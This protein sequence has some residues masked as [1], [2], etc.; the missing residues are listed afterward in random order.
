VQLQLPADLFQRLHSGQVA[1]GQADPERAHLV[2]L[3]T[4]M[5]PSFYLAS[6]GRILV[7]DAILQ[8]PLEEADRRGAIGAL[9]LGARNLRAPVLLSLL[10]PRSANAHDCVRCTGSGWW[11]LPGETKPAGAKILCPDCSG[12]GWAG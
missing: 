9:I 2:W 6:D 12:L 7:D 8:T 1:R 4:D 11:A 3:H 10:P 5:G